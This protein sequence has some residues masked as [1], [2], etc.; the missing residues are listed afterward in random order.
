M[1]PNAQK[2]RNSR[3]RTRLFV[4]SLAIG[5]AVPLLSVLS[6]EPPPARAADPVCTISPTLVNSC[7][8]WLGAE[9]G[10]YGPSG[11]RARMLE[12]EAR[13]GRQ[14][15]VVHAY[16]GAGNIVLTPDIVT[17]AK[18]ANTIA[19]V[20]WRVANRWA[21]GGGGNSTVNAQIDRM[22]N[23]I[24]AL[25]STK[26]MLTLHHEPENDISPGG[27][28]ACP[29]VRF[30]GRYGMSSQYRAMWHNVRARFDALGITN[31][32]W[33]MNYM[34]W[35]AW[36]CSTK[37]LW[38]G[39]DYVDWVMWD[40]YPRNA[41][42][43]T[44]LNSFYNYLLNNSDAEHAF[45]SKPWGLAE[46]GYVG[47]SQVAARQMYDDMRTHLNRGTYPRLKLY[48]VWD[49]WVR[50]QTN[51]D[52]VGYTANHVRDPIEQQ[53]YNAFANDPMLKGTAVPAP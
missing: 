11:F 49:N 28:P 7:R 44:F 32:V 47:T 4:G 50:N 20:N 33:V 31:V 16:L 3:P 8:P 9:S 19:L 36:H 40:P 38:P 45:T 6:P 39:N 35:K 12:H 30:V 48:S 26:I 13:I 17:L 22:G 14:L 25:G 43:T 21:D 29:Q 1:S 5:L 37:G 46:F 15:D 24:K 2:T 53:H 18:R 27:D 42:W 34:G 10:G 51:D 52:R 23:S 41:T